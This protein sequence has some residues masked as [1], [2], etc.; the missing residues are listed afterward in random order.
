MKKW[1]V[2]S[3]REAPLP[4]FK[5]TTENKNYLL[6]WAMVTQIEA[7]KDFLS[8]QFACEIGLVQLS[9]DESMEALFENME[10]ERVH[11]IR[12]ELLACRIIPV[13]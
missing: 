5:L 9:S 8:L 2:V 6:S 3:M 13:R 4:R 12:G 7:S 11:C 10:A 1:F